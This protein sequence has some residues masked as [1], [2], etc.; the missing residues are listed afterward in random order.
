[1]PAEVA[2]PGALDLDPQPAAPGDGGRFAALFETHAAH[3]FDYCH[4]L[5]AD[6]Q[7]AANATQATLVTAYALTDRLQDASRLRAWLFSLARRE[8]LSKH[9]IRATMPKPAR[10]AAPERV[11]PA[12]APGLAGTDFATADSGEPDTE[13]LRLVQIGAAAVALAGLPAAEREVLDLVYRHYVS[14]AELPAVLAMPADAAEALLAAAAIGFEATGLESAEESSGPAPA[15]PVRAVSLIPLV[16]LPP[17]IR[18]R[19]ASVVLD[20]GLA[21]YR[22]SLGASAGEFEPDGF[23]LPE[24]PA[25]PPRKRLVLSSALLAAL[26]L[27]PA[28]VG[29]TAFSIFGTPH[30]ISHAITAILGQSP[31]TPSNSASSSAGP[32][33]HLPNSAIIPPKRATGGILP[34]LPPVPKPHPSRKPHPSPTATSKNPTTSPSPWPSPS[35]TSPSGSPSSSPSTSPSSSPSGTPTSSPSTSAS[36]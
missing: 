2:R 36:P 6:R 29:A 26:L 16:P 34:V 5:L 32:T 22:D 19:T 23:P 21:S 28:A 4:S 11:D 1:V 20:P 8:C 18:R 24:Q 12:P 3:L 9:P 10:D 30:V 13:E 17:S 14:P 33:P 25:P 31:A 15:T 7:D 27:A 35:N